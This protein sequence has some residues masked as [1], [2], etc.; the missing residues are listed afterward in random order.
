MLARHREEHGSERKTGG[1]RL[2]YLESGE[3]Y[4][5]KDIRRTPMEM[6]LARAPQKTPA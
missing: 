1:R 4:T 3:Y 5:L 6:E 2:R